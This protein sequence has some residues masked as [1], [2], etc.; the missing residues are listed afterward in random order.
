M[1]LGTYRDVDMAAGQPLAETL[2]A[3]AREPVV[4]RI[5]LEGLGAAEVARA[6]ATTIIGSRP[7][8]RLVHAVH[9]RTEGNPFFVTELVRLLQSEGDLHADDTL[10]AA[11][12]EIPVGVRDVLRRRLARL[13]EQTN[14]VLLVAAAAGREFDLGLVEAVTRLDEERALEA[15]E[16]AVV[17]GLLVEDEKWAS[18][19]PPFPWAA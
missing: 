7:G 9:D 16:V 11:R 1:V 10:A 5:S 19:S 18:S 4:E 15:I 6:R 17:A 2:G 14:A 8:E 3:L 13:P 12:R